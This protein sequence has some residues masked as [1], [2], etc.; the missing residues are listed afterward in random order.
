MIGLSRPFLA[1]S[2]ELTVRIRPARLCMID[3]HL[4]H[5]PHMQSSGV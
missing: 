1:D 4:M 2:P 3:V 5:A